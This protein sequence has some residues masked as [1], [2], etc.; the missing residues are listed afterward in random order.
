[1]ARSLETGSFMFRRAFLLGLAVAVSGAGPSL[2]QG[3]ADTL[4]AELR[5]EGYRDIVVSRTLLGRLRIQA[6]RNGRVREIVLNPNSGE[7]LRDLWLVEARDD[8]TQ[9][10]GNSTRRSDS[11]GGSD[12]GNGSGSSGSGSDDGG[13]DD[14]GGDDGG[15]DDGGSDDSGGDDGGHDDDSGSGG[16]SSGSGSS[17]GG[18]D[19]GDDDHGGDNDDDHHG[20]S[21]KDD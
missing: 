11:S 21:G 14:S 3:Y 10:S 4:L 1:M 19:D 8:D 5:R 13:G 2:A 18:S 12:D 6:A 16:G 9:G 17:G 7:I 15:S 20:G